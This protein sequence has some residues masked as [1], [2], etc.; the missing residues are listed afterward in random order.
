MT[1][2]LSNQTPLPPPNP[3]QPTCIMHHTL[4]SDFLIRKYGL[5]KNLDKI[6]FM[7]NWWPFQKNANEK[8][9]LVN[10]IFRL[11]MVLWFPQLF[12][13][14]FLLNVMSVYDLYLYV[15]L[16][17]KSH[18]TISIFFK[19]SF[20]PFK[21]P[22]TKNVYFVLKSYSKLKNSFPKRNFNIILIVKYY[23]FVKTLFHSL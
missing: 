21:S 7:I 1:S 2:D 14:F 3:T 22:N 11:F 15:T 18:L 5:Y 4:L 17:F 6:I 16:T 10:I 8:N 13:R 23:I 9:I 19:N 12:F 20:K